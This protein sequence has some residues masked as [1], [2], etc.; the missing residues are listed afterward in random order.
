MKIIK[1]G[2]EVFDY[3]I[4]EIY[5]IKCDKCGCKFE[6]TYSE[7]YLTPFCDRRINCPNCGKTFI[8]GIN[9][10]KEESK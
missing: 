7:T 9:F 10:A 5:S 3:Y 2:K 4:E 1:N 8:K 6:F